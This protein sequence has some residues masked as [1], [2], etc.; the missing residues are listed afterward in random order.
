MLFIVHFV[1]TYTDVSERRLICDVVSLSEVRPL[2]MVD[3]VFS[4]PN[5]FAETETDI[6]LEE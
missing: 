3:L 2:K 6:E 1:P 5:I 4:S